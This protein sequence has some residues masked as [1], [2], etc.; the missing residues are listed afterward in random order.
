M[1]A[2]PSII[3]RHIGPSKLLLS[4]FWCFFIKQSL[5]KLLHIGIVKKKKISSKKIIRLCHFQNWKERIYLLLKFTRS[6]SSEMFFKKI[7]LNS[8]TKCRRKHLCRSL[9]LIIL[10]ANF[11]KKELRRKCFHV[12]FLKCFRSASLQ[13]TSGQLLRM[14]G[15]R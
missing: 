1:E 10:L 12:N 7:N 11:T 5:E 6:S 3:K 14:A 15:N 9:F 2:I 13:N 4:V 8:S